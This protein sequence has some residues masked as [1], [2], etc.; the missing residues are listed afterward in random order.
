MIRLFKYDV[1]IS[2]AEEDISVAEKIAVAL[3]KR[4]LSYYYYKE[5]TTDSWGEY[6]I[7][8][9]QTVFAGT[10]RYV[11]IITSKHFTLKYWSNIELQVALN[12]VKKAKANILQLRLD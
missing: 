1:A 11:L 12:D 9:T 7:H 6:L 8:L 3:K 5:H 10:S 4:K 2:V